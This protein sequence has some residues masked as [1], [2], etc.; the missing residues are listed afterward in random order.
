MTAAG[1]HKLA[2]KGLSQNGYIHVGGGDGDGVDDEDDDD[3]VDGGFSG[4]GTRPQNP[5][6]P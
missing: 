2:S 6:K 5:T 4:R 1:S 3:G